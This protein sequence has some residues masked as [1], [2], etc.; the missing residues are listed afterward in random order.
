MSL[1][2]RLRQ[3]FAAALEEA[4][5]K[6]ESELQSSLA[7]VHDHHTREREAAVAEARLDAVAELT[8]AF[9]EQKAALLSGHESALQEARAAAEATLAA[10]RQDAETA[11]VAARAEAER[12]Q[13]EQARLQQ[14]AD[15][16]AAAFRETEHAR[17]HAV[18]ALVAGARR[19]LEGV[20]ALDGATSL[21]EVLD[22][23][24]AASA[25]QSGRAAM[26]VVKGNRLLGWRTT[27]F[28]ELDGQPRSNRIVH[29][30]RRCLGARRCHRQASGDRQRAGFERPGFHP[31]CRRSRRHRRAAAGRWPRGGR[32][33]CRQSR[34]DDRRPA[35]AGGY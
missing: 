2:D 15:A 26:L 16:N 29:R 30:R 25:A 3:S 21:S 11:L 28:D 4:R 23:L 9:D 5:G 13:I 31:G 6:L 19:M 34:C 1:E 7:S 8:R 24:T 27:G 32:G 12:G 22:A 18:D 10:A 35:I 14:Q 20:K 17:A 33:L